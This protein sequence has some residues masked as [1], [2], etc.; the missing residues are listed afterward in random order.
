VNWLFW[1]ITDFKFGNSPTAC[2]VYN[3]HTL[4]LTEGC[5]RLLE[6]QLTSV[7]KIEVLKVGEMRARP[8]YLQASLDTIR[9]KGIDVL[10]RLKTLSAMV[11]CSTVVG[12]VPRRI[13]SACV[14]FL[15]HVPCPYHAC[16]K[17]ILSFIFAL[18]IILSGMY[19]A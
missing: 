15:A 6:I 8:S 11:H 19:I 10:V 12:H 7:N 5:E 2:N 17:S 13:S 3:R 9:W 18:Y 4:K 1:S 14:L 16:S